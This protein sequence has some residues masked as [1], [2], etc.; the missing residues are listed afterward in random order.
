MGLSRRSLLA[1][2]AVFSS[3][4]GQTQ[5]LGSE[6][7]RYAD[8]TTEAEVIR[9]TNPAFDSLLPPPD[10]RAVDRR[11]HSLL[12]ASNRTG[13]WQPYWMDLFTG[14]SH[15][16]PC[17][18]GF[19]P[20]CLT[21]SADDKS[22]LFVDGGSVVDTTLQ[23]MK[24]RVLYQLPEG[25]KM[26]GGLSPA[27][28]G[29]WIFFAEGKDAEHRIVRMRLPKGTVD[30]VLGGSEPFLDLSPSSRR[31]TLLWRSPG[32]ELWVAGFDGKG[33][34]KIETPPGRVLQA[35]WGPGGRNIL[36]LFEPAETGQL[37]QIREQDLDSRSDTRLASTSQFVSFAANANASVF[38]GA[39]R[40][41]ASPNLLVLLRSTRRELTLCEHKAK[42]PLHV[43]VLFTPDSQRLFFQSDRDGKTAIYMM[44]LERLIE[45][46]DT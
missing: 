11:N 5:V 45:K 31:A 43:P 19:D 13:T 14:Q 39:S 30:M 10:S 18:A 34:R 28:E 32:G 22:V 2:F 37:T 24:Q 12:Y 16:L 17:G 44:N 20:R 46:T 6:A 25:W 8:P 40:S 4:P 1:G 7:R 33:R 23:N 41:K 35:Q 36:Y 26:Q 42:N 21:Y 15:L 9:L 3:Q 38:L 27:D 29:G